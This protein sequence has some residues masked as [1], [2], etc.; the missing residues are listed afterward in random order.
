MS[1]TQS[2]PRPAVYPLPGTHAETIRDYV[3]A[4]PN[5]TTNGIIEGLKMNPSV[6]RKC[7]AV[8]V[9][10]GVL[11]DAPDDNKHHHYTAKNSKL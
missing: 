6:V 8:L 9:D 2:S 7:L 10:R 1:K 4:N 5:T 11:V 3:I